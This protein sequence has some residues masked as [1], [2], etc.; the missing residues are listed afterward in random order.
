MALEDLKGGR[1]G[2]RG[3]PPLNQ[4]QTYGELIKM[5]FIYLVLSFV[6]SVTTLLCM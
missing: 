2:G 4:G 6:F 5:D 3:Q 1:E